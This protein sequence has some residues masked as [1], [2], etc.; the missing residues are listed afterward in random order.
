MKGIV[1]R[2]EENVV[3][4]EVGGST[5]DVDRSLVSQ[6][7]RE[8]SVVQFDGKQWILLEEETHERSKRIQEKMRNLFE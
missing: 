3:V 7:V 6:D 1:D 5:Q 2:I 8:G 4:I